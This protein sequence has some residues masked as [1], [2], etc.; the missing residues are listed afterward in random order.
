MTGTAAPVPSYSEHHHSFGMATLVDDCRLDDGFALEN[1][2]TMSLGAG[3][4]ATAS[5]VWRPS[6][7]GKVTS[8]QFGWGY[9]IGPHVG[10][11]IETDVNTATG[12]LTFPEDFVEGKGRGDT[13]FPTS[14]YENQRERRL[15][16]SG[17]VAR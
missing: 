10:V 17:T 4:T 8:K 12:A 14:L 15:T 3:H 7:A 6:G 9:V 13:L 1:R 2:G 5:V 16:K 11:S